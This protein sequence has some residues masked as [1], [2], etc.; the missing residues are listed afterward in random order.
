MSIIGLAIYS[1]GSQR[2]R[3][4]YAIPSAK[5]APPK[6][7]GHGS[8]HGVGIRLRF[9]SQRLSHSYAMDE[10]CLQHENHCVKNMQMRYSSFFLSGCNIII[11]CEAFSLIAVITP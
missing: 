8:A 2:L 5:I 9:G 4:S 1:I 7:C 6:K 10:N 11:V 3:H